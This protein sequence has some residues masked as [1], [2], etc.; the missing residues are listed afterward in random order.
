MCGFKKGAFEPACCRA[1]APQ[2]GS[3][4]S[5][6]SCSCSTPY[7]LPHSLQQ[8]LLPDHV[9]GSSHPQAT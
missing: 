1:A 5:T 9:R 3:S 8:G 2:I 7:S 6:P 4:S